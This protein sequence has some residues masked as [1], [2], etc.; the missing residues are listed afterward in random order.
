MLGLTVQTTPPQQ[1]VSWSN[2]TGKPNKRV[3]RNN[4]W[5]DGGSGVLFPQHGESVYFFYDP[6]GSNGD[7]L[8]FIER[9]IYSVTYNGSKFSLFYVKSDS[10]VAAGTTTRKATIYI[11]AGDEGLALT[12]VL[13]FY[14]INYS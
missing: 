7:G 13:Y 1:S 12:S 8:N 4:V 9:N 14:Q 5:G 11:L 10:Q 3:I 6:A 2:I